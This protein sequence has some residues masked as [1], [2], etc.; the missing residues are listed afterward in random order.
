MKLFFEGHQNMKR[1]Y[2]YINVL[3]LKYKV[4]ISTLQFSLP[5]DQITQIASLKSHT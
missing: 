2:T 1:I 5:A 3:R 4:L